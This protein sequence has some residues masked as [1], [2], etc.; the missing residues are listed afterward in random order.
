[1]SKVLQERG[2]G[3]L[4]SS[5]KINPIDHVKSILT[6]VESEVYPIRRIK[7]LQYVVSMPQNSSKFFQKRS[8][9]PDFG[10]FLELNDLNEPL[11]L[12]R[13]QVE[14]LGHTIEEGEVTNAPIEEI[15]KT[16]NDNDE[17]TNRIEDY[18]IKDKL[19]YKGENVVGAFMNVPIFIGTFSVVT[20]CAV[21]EDMDAYRDKKNRRCDMNYQMARSHP[22][23]KCLTN[24]Q[25]NK[26]PP[27]LKVSAQDKLQGIPHPYQ[28]LKRLY[29][30]VLNLGPEY[31]KED[32]VD[33]WLTRRHVSVHE[34]E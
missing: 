23:F 15:V 34:M 27:L 16:R 20:D 1:M 8:Q 22:R 30:G 9:D 17:I 33:E 28:K 14:D 25:C 4:P 5:T 13:N 6:T 3:G 11:E 26:I 10:D 2:S 29:K 21:L 31:I 19:E 7:P 12:R 32:K 24:E 18:P